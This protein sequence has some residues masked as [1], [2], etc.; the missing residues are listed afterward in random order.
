[1]AIENAVLKKKSPGTFVPGFRFSFSFALSASC[2]KFQRSVINHSLRGE[3]RPVESLK[4]VVL[5]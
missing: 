4:S 2:H 3:G 5:F 1:M